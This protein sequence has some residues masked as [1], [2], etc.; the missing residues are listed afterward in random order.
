MN[1]P[2]RPPLAFVQ[3]ETSLPASSEFHELCRD[4]GI[5][6]EEAEIDRLGRFLALLLANNEVLNLTAIKGQDEGWKKHVFDALT[7]LSVLHDLP[8]GAKI[9][10]LGSGGGVPA[11]PLALVL[12]RQS[13]TL[14]E[15]TAKKV[16]YLEQAAQALGLANV[17]VVNERAETLGRN[18]EHREQ[19][20]AVI[21]R[22][23][24]SLRIIAEFGL[25]LAKVRGRCAFIKGARATD[26]LE[27][28]ARALQLLHGRY[29]GTLP[30]PTGRIVVL[31]KTQATPRK[32]PRRPGEPKRLP[33]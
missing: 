8:D 5:E 7:L 2:D 23:L 3:A 4:F 20:D 22:A 19:Y 26:E 14:V 17:R 27:E 9:A 25:P 24:G 13:F 32:Y 29:D 16:R 15:S 11:L 12:P 33:L 31:A 10:D 30:T 18:R 1:G 6:L 21:A 28:A